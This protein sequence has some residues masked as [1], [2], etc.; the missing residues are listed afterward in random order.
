MGCAT[1][2]SAG[3]QAEFSKTIGERDLD[4][5]AELS[6]D[7]DPI[8]VDEE[9]ARNTAFGRRIA[10]GGLVMSLLSTTAS[11][12][13]RRSQDRGS[14][15]NSV[16]IGYDRIRFLKPVFIG[17]TLT[18]RYT[19]EEVDDEAGRTRSKVEVF[20][21]HGELCLVGAHIMKWVPKDGTS[22][23]AVVEPH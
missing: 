10:H 5:F 20:N 3:E 1:K 16:S 13:S 6:G 14:P 21:Q 12:M 15:G 11:T 2:L 22:K 23:A 18:A 19:I 9:Y 8:H 7:F 4:L 17:D